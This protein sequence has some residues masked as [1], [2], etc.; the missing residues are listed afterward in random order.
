[1]VGCVPV[2]RL[3]LLLQAMTRPVSKALPCRVADDVRFTLPAAA[4]FEQRL[5]G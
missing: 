5:G 2:G 1:M 4:S 3:T